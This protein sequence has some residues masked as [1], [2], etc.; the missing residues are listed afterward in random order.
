MKR[1][2]FLALLLTL[3]AP[4]IA[5]TH[6]FAS[7]ATPA[8]LSPSGVE[9]AID[10]SG[11]LHLIDRWKSAVYRRAADGTISLVAGTPGS[12]GSRDGADALFSFPRSPVFDRLG[13]LYLVDTENDTLRRIAPDGVVTTLRSNPV[14]GTHFAEVGNP[15]LFNNPLSLA[16]SA[17]GILY[18]GEQGVQN[19]PRILRLGTGGMLSVFAGG[20]SSSSAPPDG[21]GTQASFRDPH[22]MAV[23]ASGNLFVAD[24]YYALRKVTPAGDVSTVVGDYTYLPITDGVGALA[25]FNTLGSLTFASD[26]TLY[27][28]DAGGTVVRTV[29]PTGVIT[30]IAGQVHQARSEDGIGGLARFELISG[31]ALDAT[32]NLYVYSWGLKRGTPVSGAV[33]PILHT[34]PFSA[35]P[36]SME[37]GANT[38]LAFTGIAS[39]TPPLFYQWY[40][41]GVQLPGETRPTLEFS[42]VTA[43]HEGTYVLEVSN[44]AG[45]VRSNPRAISVYSPR[46]T[47]FSSVHARP[48][49]GFLWGIARG[50]RHF[51]AVGTEGT[52][53]IST[54][55]Q[56]WERRP[57]GTSDWLV[58][59]VYIRDRF[60]AVGDRGT[61]LSSFDALNWQRVPQ[62]A[63]TQRLNNIVFGM[64]KLVAV[65]EGG[66]IITSDD[67]QTWTRR[68]SGVT[69]WL[70]GLTFEPAERVEGPLAPSGPMFYA[71]GQ[72][73]VAL[74]S[75]DGMTWSS[76]TWPQPG[77]PND[78]EA[79]ASPEVVTVGADGAVNYRR[80]YYYQRA[81]GAS[82]TP[83]FPTNYITEAFWSWER[84]N[85]GIPARFR[86]IARG[87]GAYFA[88]GE[89]GAIAAA[90]SPMGPWAVVPS[91]T[92]ANLVN[93]GFFGDKLYLVGENETILVSDPLY[94]TRLA[95]LSTRGEGSITSGFV[96]SG[97]RPKRVLL[98]GI[99]PSLVL[100]GLPG[101]PR[102]ALRLYDGRSQL[103]A[104]NAGWHTAPNPADIATTSTRV[105]AF[106][107]ATNSF[108]S[109]LL[110]ELSPGAYTVEVARDPSSLF[111]GGGNLLL[112]IYDAD[113]PTASGPRAINL[114]S[115]GRVEPGKSLIAG[116]VVHGADSRTLL[117]RGIG[118]ALERFGVPEPL[119]TPRLRLFDSRGQERFSTAA[120]WSTSKDVAAIRAAITATGAFPLQEDT[121]DTALIVTLPPGTYTAEVAGGTGHALVEVYEVP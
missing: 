112:E 27:I 114:S 79:L 29:S 66:T 87:A 18:I 21:P 119:A 8:A 59:V 70:R 30:T 115:R 118:P 80:P 94:P 6:R 19:S 64:G 106:P 57:S 101:E 14:T 78:H 73:A 47:G 67:G 22:S 44:A 61:I 88:T 103:I 100:F 26:G 85:I 102:P 65:G 17:S 120:S 58:A 1:A 56:T 98:R 82:K 40:R 63:T 86:F 32:G 77:T 108:D 109:A 51:V 45:S 52:I 23:D 38:R 35:T 84:I 104:Q 28:S 111:P 99:G 37:V 41:N 110:A 90:S 24:S 49:G 95:N 36:T 76:A 60:F 113:A 46:L 43:A 91:G 89:Q 20:N 96:L 69:T 31:L 10:P 16:I 105:G 11:T 74:M 71:V 72:N 55:G 97:T 9:L 42:N 92:T 116:V 117:I 39:G 107:I 12:F 68:E 50:L 83:P 15:V 2:L 25:R 3:V 5:Q 81:V 121:L 93:G 48:G 7:L 33:P 4:L 75:R 34:P 53:L 13:N 62:T 54:D